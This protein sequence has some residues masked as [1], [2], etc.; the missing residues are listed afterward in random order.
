MCCIATVTLYF[1][2]EGADKRQVTDLA[3]QWKGV[4][5]TREGF[6]SNVLARSPSKRSTV[7]AEISI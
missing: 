7:K 6:D 2:L 3:V 4:I 5:A 1:P